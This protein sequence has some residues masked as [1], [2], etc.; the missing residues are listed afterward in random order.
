MGYAFKE[1]TDHDIGMV[2]QRIPVPYLGAGLPMVYYHDK[3]VRAQT[4]RLGFGVL[5]SADLM[6]VAKSEA[7]LFRG[8]VRASF[9]GR[10]QYDDDG[11]LSISLPKID[12]SYYYGALN[13]AWLQFNGLKVGIQPSLFGFNRVP[14]IL[15]PAYTSEITTA[16]VSFTIGY[17]PNFSVSI[18]AE[19]GG[20]RN[21][22]EGILSRES[23]R[24]RKPDWIGLVRYARGNSLYHFSAARHEATDSVMRDFAGGEKKPV[25]GW[26]AAAGFQTKIEWDKYF[27]EAFA[28]NPGRLS[29]TAAATEGAVGYLG[30]PFFAPD[31]VVS[32]SGEVERTTGW[33][34]VAAY[35]HI[36]APKWKSTLSYS[37]FSVN[38]ESP[39]EA[40]IP[41]DF[42]I[43]SGTFNFDV[44][45]TGS[46]LQAGL[47]HILAPGVTAGFEVGYTWTEAKGRYAG[48]KARD[49]DVA[50]PHVGFYLRRSF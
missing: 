26:A 11:D 15:N 50:Y 13:E 20:R 36:L 49:L 5:A 27:G 45:V 43:P 9:D 14:S 41:A 7:G 46:V 1:L 21:Y 48:Y 34:A 40:I 17:A 22:S 6:L 39:V 28:R 16:A 33:S 30:I 3:D 4:D 31:Y 8:Y 24:L 2:G 37:Y 47:E 10:S 32:A 25:S 42:N 18:S 35:E 19:D 44:T 38:M 23:S 12:N 29:I